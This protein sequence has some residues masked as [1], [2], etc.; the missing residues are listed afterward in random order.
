M[1]TSPV[2]TP[3]A[4][5]L[6]AF[7]KEGEH[8]G[9][10]GAAG[11]GVR[12][13]VGVNAGQAVV[14]LCGCWLSDEQLSNTADR[15]YVIGFDEKTTQALACAAASA[16][17]PHGACAAH[18]RRL[19]AAYGLPIAL[20]SLLQAKREAGD[21]LVHLD[22]R[23]AASLGRLVAGCTEASNL[24]IS[25][26]PD[27][28]TA[29]ATGGRAL[30]RRLYLV[31][32]HE[33]PPLTEFTWDHANALKRRASERAADKGAGGA[34]GDAV[35][36]AALT[37]KRVRIERATNPRTVG[38]QVEVLQPEKGGLCG[39]RYAAQVLAAGRGDG[40]VQLQ[41]THLYEAAHAKSALVEWSC[42]FRGNDDD[43]V[44]RP[45]PPPPPDGFAAALQPG[46]EVEVRFEEGWWP[47]TVDSAPSASIDV[48]S[49]EEGLSGLTRTVALEQVRPSWRWLGVLRGG[50]SY[51][52]QSGG[53][54]TVNIHGEKPAAAP[55]PAPAAAAPAV[56]AL[57]EAAAASAAAAAAAAP[58]AASG[59]GDGGE[60]GQV[61]AGGFGCAQSFQ[62]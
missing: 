32:K 29:A 58:N 37:A 40:M 31:A 48:R 17:I 28:A 33:I 47:V 21:D 27:A 35:L 52:T 55:A 25:A 3:C 22:M 50:W 38:A 4:T 53:A 42:N 39:A 41:Y 18:A 43:E 16:C 61:P 46:D 30:P 12:S 24:E 5:A 11:W 45:V 59:P 60:G 8:R 14:E 13:T 26:W 49:A 54:H 34:V 7:P 51:A 36:A 20:P 57:A 23:E 2:L 19:P 1:C 62:L 15:S 44:L 6:Q 9:S 56:V 10:W